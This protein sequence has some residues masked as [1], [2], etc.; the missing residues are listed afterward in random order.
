MCYS[1]LGDKGN[2]NGAVEKLME[3]LNEVSVS[4]KC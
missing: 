2:M 4:D 1:K 3:L